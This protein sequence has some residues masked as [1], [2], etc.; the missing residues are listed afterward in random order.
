[1]EWD[2]SAVFQLHRFECDVMWKRSIENN[3]FASSFVLSVCLHPA[4]ERR[5]GSEQREA[6]TLPP[7]ISNF[8]LKTFYRSCF[9]LLLNAFLHCSCE[10]CQICP[11]RNNGLPIAIVRLMFV[12]FI[13]SDRHH[14]W[15][16]CARWVEKLLE[17]KFA[18]L[19]VAMAWQL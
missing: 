8:L 15:C 18:T 19:P 1:M 14:T 12:T 5:I 2:S 13:D 7:L 3:A 11:L 17:K 10:N 6:R 4:G 16:G 9:I